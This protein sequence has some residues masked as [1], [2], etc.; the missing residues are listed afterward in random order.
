VN[1]GDVYDVR[2]PS[3]RR[4]AVIVTRERAIPVLTNVTVAEITRTVRGAPTEVPLGPAQGLRSECV[5][6][7]DNLATLPKG[8][9]DRYRGTLGPEEIRL[10]DTALRIALGL[11]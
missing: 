2:F 10:L 9:L 4:P 3:G 8:T 1:R 11:D 5:A 7:C 6:N